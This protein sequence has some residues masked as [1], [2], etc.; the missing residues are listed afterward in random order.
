MISPISKKF[1]FFVISFNST[2]RKNLTFLT[3]EYF[4][5]DIHN[6]CYLQFLT[7]KIHRN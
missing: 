3:L 6:I 7:S 1:I 5:L 4:F 2:G